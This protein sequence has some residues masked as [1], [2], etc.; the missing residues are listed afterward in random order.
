MVLLDPKTYELKTIYLPPTHP[1]YNDETGTGETLPFKVG[2][3]WKAPVFDDS[4]IPWCTY[5]HLPHCGVGQRS[6]Q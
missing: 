4:E 5:S 2:K 3:Y 6:W 1:T